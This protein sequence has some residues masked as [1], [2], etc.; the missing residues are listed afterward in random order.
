[1]SRRGDVGGTAEFR[2]G[3]GGALHAEKLGP[4]LRKRFVFELVRN[5]YRTTLEGFCDAPASLI[6]HAKFTP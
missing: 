6:L 5:S 3:T 1:M 4:F 2:S